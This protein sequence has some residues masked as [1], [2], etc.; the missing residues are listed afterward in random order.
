M[1]G[2]RSPSATTL[3]VL[4]VAHLAVACT[5]GHGDGVARGGAAIPVDG[6]LGTSDGAMGALLSDG[7]DTLVDA[8]AS[9]AAQLGPPVGDASDDASLAYLDSGSDAEDA[10]GADGG[11]SEDTAYVWDLPPGFPVPDVP[12]DNP[13]SAAK[14]ELGK[15]LF[16]DTRLS[17]NQT[18]ACASCH[19]QQKAFTD[20]L[21]QAI[22]SQG[23]VLP[24][25]A[26]SL[27]N[28][29]YAAVL[30]W[31]DPLI[32]S[33]EQQAYLPMFNDAPPELG[34]EGQESN[35][36]A[37][38]R[39]DP[40]YAQLFPAAFPTPADP[41]TVLSIEQAIASFERTL[42]SGRSAYDRY[43]YSGDSSAMSDAALAGMNLFFNTDIVPCSECH[44]EI[45]FA[46]ATKWV[47]KSLVSLAFQNNGL[48][49]IGGT[50]AYPANNSG[51]FAITNVPS[52]MGKF[53][54]PTL[55]NLGYTAPYFH[56]GSAATL[57]DVIA[58]YAAGGRTIASGPYAGDGALSP[59]K[60]GLLT[61]FT[62]TQ[63]QTD[64]LVA[65]LLSLDDPEFVSDPRLAN[66]WQ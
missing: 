45:D 39:A 59:Y 64:D 57:Y 66:P 42:I 16:Y 48:Y 14:V 29:A 46:G 61:G 60:D 21:P 27:T 17:G 2:T 28:V 8:A 58:N 30:T 65:F 5:G 24:R 10:T 13:M 53:K 3:T 38:L 11:G 31:M 41:F 20:G 7:G 23:G 43:V 40:F 37:R 62:L 22:G 32:A 36:F 63:E 52:D 25:S 34:L 12:A 47:G 49:N 51:L 19:D 35:L 54:A 44:T 9:D 56:D 55:R 6:G 1:S 33:L 15:R 26:M 4:A 50:G 18:Y